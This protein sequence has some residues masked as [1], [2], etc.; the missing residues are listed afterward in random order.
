MR[1]IPSIAPNAPDLLKHR[2]VGASTGF[3]SDHYG[4]WPALV[5]QAASYSTMAVEL[6]ALSETEL[7]SLEKFFASP[8]LLLPFLYVSIHGPSKQRK[9]PEPD[10]VDKLAGLVRHAS[11]IVI[12]PDTIED[13]MTYRAL[14]SALVL[15]NMDG[16]KAIGQTADDLAYYFDI[17]PDAGFCFDIPHAAS[18]D[19]SLALGHELLN[20]HGHRLRHVHL[21][22]LDADSHHRSL[23]SADR[24][25]FGPLLD[26]CRDVPWILEAPAT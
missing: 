21:S 5:L 6:S 22:S 25:R 2:L 1:M 4:D 10:L 3:M 9:L 19:P 23:T 17:L 18:V 16:R 24:D 7:P 8:E 12:H 13:P 20:D 11:A 14:G 15:E 26:R